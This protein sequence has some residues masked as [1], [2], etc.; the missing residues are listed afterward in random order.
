MAQL[1]ISSAQILVGTEFSN[2]SP[3]RG[4]SGKSELAALSGLKGQFV[5][6][7]RQELDKK[8][9]L[10]LSKSVVDIDPQHT[11]TTQSKVIGRHGG[12]GRG[13]HPGGTSMPEKRWP[14]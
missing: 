6:R 3:R 9:V 5:W 12:E 1:V 13:R 7:L 2:H 11:L 10:F 8:N 4:R 14:G